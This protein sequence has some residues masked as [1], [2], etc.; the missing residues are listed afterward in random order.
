ML[1]KALEGT[2]Q[3]VK[4]MANHSYSDGSTEKTFTCLKWGWEQEHCRKTVC[5]ISLNQLT[6]RIRLHSDM[7]T[8]AQQ[9]PTPTERVQKGG[10]EDVHTSRLIDIHDWSTLN[11]LRLANFLLTAL[12]G[13]SPYPTFHLIHVSPYLQVVICWNTRKFTPLTMLTNTPTRRWWNA[14]K[15]AKRRLRATRGGGS[16]TNTQPPRWS[17]NANY[18]P[19]QEPQK[20][21]LK[22]QWSVSTRVSKVLRNHSG[23][24]IIQN[25]L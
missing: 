23:E 18:Y 9:P 2:T 12:F 4:C 11:W 3:T 14:S 16:R 6:Y 7:N 25:K 8:N 10:N 20:F 19:R 24:R 15:N 22:R 21:Y 17:T 5:F 13:N 1:E